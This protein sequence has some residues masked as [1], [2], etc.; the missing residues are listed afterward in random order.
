MALD[1]HAMWDHRRP[2]VSEQ[3]FRD[4]LADASDDDALILKTQIARTHGV[5]R[6]F[7]RAQ[8]LLAQI[9]DESRGAGSEAQAHHAL[10][11]GRALASATH[12]VEALTPDA[13]QE[14]RGHFQRALEIARANGHDA[15]AVDALHMF[16][17]LDTVPADQ[18]KWAREALGVV[19]ASTQPAAKHWE[20]SLR[21][22]AGYAL[23]QLGRYDEALSEFEQAVA[24]RERSD[25]A[26]AT[27]VAKW[28]VGWT[29]RALGRLEEALAMQ[30]RLVDE[31]EAAGEPDPYVFEELEA[32]C[33]AKG[34]PARAAEFAAR[35]QACAK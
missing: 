26:S 24:L 19:D 9:A 5:R 28:M 1:L 27:R 12:P 3:R 21:N 14:A 13:R 7:A 33:V 2:E 34:D 17:F 10:E 25:N 30:L 4:A 20:A 31:C 8:E 11:S 6:D 23:H 16:A 29:L 32:L 18:L 22:N 15:L 35:K